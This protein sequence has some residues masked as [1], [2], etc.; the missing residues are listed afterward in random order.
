[1]DTFL[2]RLEVGKNEAFTCFLLSAA[3]FLA[4]KMSQIYCLAHF[5]HFELIS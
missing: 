4:F 2:V 1:M 5:L 3:G